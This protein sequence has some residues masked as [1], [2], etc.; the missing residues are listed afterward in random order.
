MGA[1]Y[2]GNRVRVFALVLICM[3]LNVSVTLAGPSLKGD[4]L[5]SSTMFDLSIM[6]PPLAMKEQCVQHLLRNN[7]FPAIT[8]T[9]EEL[10]AF[11][12]NEAIDE[13]IRPDIVFAQAL[14]ETGYFKFGGDVVPLQNNY[15][16]L[17]TT[18]NGRGG[19]WFFTAQ[20][21]VRA[22][23]QHLLGYSS[24]MPPKK[25]IVDPRY[26]LVKHSKHFGTV[27]TWTE[28]NGKWAVPGINYGQKILKIHEKIMLE[29]I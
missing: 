8:V 16:G 20:I 12:Y 13:G 29:G 25:E 15:C 1:V 17:G 23:V 6:G 22:Q 18:G 10:V 4:E 14:L 28:L 3:F 5:N 21:G 2:G 19:A 26:T 9:P 24:T 7:P 11:F 27:K